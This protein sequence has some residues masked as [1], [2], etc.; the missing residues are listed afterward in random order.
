MFILEAS[1]TCERFISQL[2]GSSHSLRAGTM[3]LSLNHKV[4]GYEGCFFLKERVGLVV[5][6]GGNYLNVPVLSSEKLFF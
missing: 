6:S 3:T 2:T 4:F 5:I 1:L